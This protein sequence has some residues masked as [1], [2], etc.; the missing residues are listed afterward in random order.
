MAFC[1]QRLSHL[2]WIK[3]TALAFMPRDEAT[4]T[5]KRGYGTNH[6]GCG[7]RCRVCPLSV[8]HVWGPKSA[9][10]KLTRLRVIL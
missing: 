5:K 2:Y 7:C 9:E 1:D 8:R 10:I 6:D 3:S 4:N